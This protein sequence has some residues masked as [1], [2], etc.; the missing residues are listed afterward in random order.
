MRRVRLFA[1]C[2]SLSDMARKSELRR[3]LEESIKLAQEH[4]LPQ[5][6]KRDSLGRKL[7]DLDDDGPTSLD[8]PDTLPEPRRIT[9]RGTD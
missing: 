9:M 3:L 4:Q 5:Q 7:A 6:I 2:G 1:L 8:D